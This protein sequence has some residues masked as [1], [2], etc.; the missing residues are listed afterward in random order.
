MPKIQQIF[1]HKDVLPY[2]ESRGL[3]EQYK[4]AKQILL[5]GDGLRVRFKKRHP[6]GSGVW[7][8][9]IN[10]QF[11]ALCIFNQENDLIVFKI[12]NHQ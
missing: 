1:E 10:K 3:L 11:R 9:R 7:Y 5:K 12:D 4:K 2:L 8:F 6:H